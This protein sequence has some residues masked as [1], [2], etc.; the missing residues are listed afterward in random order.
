MSE[1]MDRDTIIN[2]LIDVVELDYDAIEAYQAAIERLSDDSYKTKLGEFQ[3][4]HERHVRELSEAIKSKGGTP[5]ESGDIKQV[6]TTGKVVIADLGGDQTI[7][8][9][10][11]S[12]EDETNSKYEEVTKLEFPENIRRL[13][14]A[15]LADE[16]RHRAWI[17]STLEKSGE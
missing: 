14:E 2:K 17:E 11:K 3:R 8:K 6:L 4:D 15:G 13:L 5:P 9:A 10:M 1:V 16:R 7:L 12:N